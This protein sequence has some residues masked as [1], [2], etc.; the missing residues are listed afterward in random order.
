MDAIPSLPE[1]RSLFEGL[2]RPG[3]I[4]FPAEV[5]RAAARYARARRHAGETWKAIAA[6]LPV[7][8]ASLAHWVA[9]LERPTPGALVP[10]VT[11]PPPPPPPP[12][13][14]PLCLVSPG[15]WRLE[16]LDLE[17]AGALL[18]RLG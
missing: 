13:R 12:P 14:S 18:Q 6:D 9:A 1:L 10:V 8:T 17:G 15:G 11:V 2:P 7:S 3:D 4:G 16:G 5:Q